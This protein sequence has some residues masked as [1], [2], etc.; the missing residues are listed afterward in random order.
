MG[1]LEVAGS[2][3]R[4]ELSEGL[5]TVSLEPLEVRLSL[6]LHRRDHLERAR[7]APERPRAPSGH[8]VRLGGGSEEMKI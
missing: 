6:F 2:P 4:T 7:E 1:F 3:K 5:G 8:P